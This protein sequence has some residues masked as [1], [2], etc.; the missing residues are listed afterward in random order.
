MRVSRCNGIEV[1]P[2][3]RAHV[4]NSLPGRWGYTQGLWDGRLLLKTLN[5]TRLCVTDRRL[6]PIWD[7][8]I[9]QS[10]GYDSVSSDLSR[11]AVTLG[12][13]VR[14]LDSGGQIVGRFR[15]AP[16]DQF[17][18]GATAFD[19]GG[20]Y[21]WAT[22]PPAEDVDLVVLELDTLREVDR[23]SF[24]SHPAGLE[25]LHHPD[26]RTIGWSIGEGQDRVL[27]RWSSLVGDRM[28]L[29]LVPD[30][31]RVLIAIHPNGHEYLTTPHSAGPIQRHRFGDDA[32]IGRLDA[33]EDMRWDFAAGYLDVDRILASVRNDDDEGL[34]LADRDPMK[35][36][37]RV[38]SEGSASPWP[39]VTW[40]GA[41]MWVTVGDVAAELW[42]LD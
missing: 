8:E 3:V 32:V 10:R 11:I 40:V 7:L 36:A 29:R 30:E 22:I 25:P 15:H 26:G 28:E 5:G 18:S 14:L 2:E 9:P 38:I 39:T 41:S 33:S 37:A 23:R 20:H 21:L 42:Q 12:E 16:W 24:E 31:D 27:I 4:V 13:E 1:I 6:V 19:R 35:I 17:S 34:L